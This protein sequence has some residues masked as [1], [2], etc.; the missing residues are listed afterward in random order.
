MAPDPANDT[1]VI[2]GGEEP[3]TPQGNPYPT[4]GAS[5]DTWTWSGVAYRWRC[6]SGA[7]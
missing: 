2:F 7:A 5:N 4:V 1:I 3:N 6:K